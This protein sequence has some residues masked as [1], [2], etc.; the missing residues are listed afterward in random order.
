[1]EA[2][3]VKE[4]MIEALHHPPQDEVKCVTLDRGREFARHEEVTKAM[5]QVKFCFPPLH[6]PWERGTKENT[7][8]L[9]REC[10]PKGYD[11]ADLSDQQ[12][13]HIF[14]L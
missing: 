5:P 8:G 12:I 4:R 2:E 3:A 13:Q 14:F 7:N 11:T 10:L 6:S 9:I 1:M